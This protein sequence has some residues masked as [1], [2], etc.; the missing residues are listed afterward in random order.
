LS[1]Q[2]DIFYRA[3]SNFSAHTTMTALFE[4]LEA[5][6]QGLATGLRWGPD[7]SGIE[8]TLMAACSASVQLVAWAGDILKSAELNEEWSR[9]RDAYKRMIG[10]M[11][12]R[13]PPT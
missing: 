2:Y 3:L 12:K 8:V 13:A 4:Q 9:C 10:E 11:G 5:D 6:E 7:G 1:K